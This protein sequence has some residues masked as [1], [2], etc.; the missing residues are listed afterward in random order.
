MKIIKSYWLCA[1]ANKWSL[2][3]WKHLNWNDCSVQASGTK[4]EAVE[5]KKHWQSF[6]SLSIQ[7]YHILQNTMHTRWN[8]N[9]VVV[10]F[11]RKKE[12]GLCHVSYQLSPQFTFNLMNPI[13]FVCLPWVCLPPRR[14]SGNVLFCILHTCS[15]RTR[16]LWILISH[17]VISRHPGGE[18]CALE[19]EASVCLD[20]TRASAGDLHFS[21][22]GE[23][24]GTWLC[25]IWLTKLSLH[26][27]SDHLRKRMLTFFTEG[28]CQAG[29]HR[30]LNALL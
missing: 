14:K 28:R 15:I 3:Q 13:I 7:T 23:N 4:S 19:C 1:S 30:R 20:V 26:C 12:A 21:I 17:F 10:F 25:W 6:I 11:T 27:G 2:K 16:A 24:S 29:G 8:E 5:K 9:S 22:S 18:F